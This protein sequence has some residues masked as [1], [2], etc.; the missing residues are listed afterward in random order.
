MAMVGMGWWFDWMSLD[1][2]L[3]RAISKAWSLKMFFF[4]FM[5][6][7]QCQLCKGSNLGCDLGISF[8][9]LSNYF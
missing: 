7:G 2:K 4:F 8:V 3:N 1:F 6:V 9:T 5:D